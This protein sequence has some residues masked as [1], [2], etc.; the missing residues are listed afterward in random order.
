M[1]SCVLGRSILRQL[2]PVEGSNRV[3]SGH[4]QQLATHKGSLYVCVIDFSADT[5]ILSRIMY[6]SSRCLCSISTVTPT[7]STNSTVASSPHNTAVHEGYIC[8]LSQAIEVSPISDTSRER[9]DDKKRVP[10][11]RCRYAGQSVATQSR[12]KLLLEVY[13]DYQ[14]RQRH[15][16]SADVGRGDQVRSEAIKLQFQARTAR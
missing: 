4:L 3:T 7:N 10:A 11:G 5:A 16:S 12:H 14:T 9:K 13:Y 15:A 1:L 8:K 6:T 2:Q